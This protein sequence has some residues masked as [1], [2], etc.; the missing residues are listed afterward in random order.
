MDEKAHLR[1][2]IEELISELSEEKKR[3]ESSALCLA[4][5][6]HIPEGST[7]CAYYPL[8]SEVDISP[9]LDELMLRGDSVF[10]PS[11]EK[12]VLTF[13]QIEGLGDV[14]RGT[15]GIPE[16]MGS[17]KDLSDGGADIVLVPGRAFDAFGN[18]LGR[19]GGTYDRWIHQ[20]RDINS[21]TRYIGI[22]FSCQV[23]S[24]IP[25]DD[26]DE[27]MDAIATEDDINRTR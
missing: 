17:A 14:H 6:P 20:Q 11:S 26:H 4:I 10:L 9:L 7:V 19:G 15:F 5:L 22:A 24:K 13:R 8:D 12:D 3:T 1:D 21:K 2:S 27:P 16:P 18:R 23:V 25:I